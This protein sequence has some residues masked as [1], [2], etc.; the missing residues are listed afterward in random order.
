M[1]ACG[2]CRRVGYSNMAV[3]NFDLDTADEDGN[4]F[5]VRIYLNISKY[6]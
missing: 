5:D 4:I 2:G 3:D 6:I 1:S